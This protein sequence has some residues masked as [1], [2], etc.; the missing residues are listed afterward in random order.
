[1]KYMALVL[2][3][4]VFCGTLCWMLHTQAPAFGWILFGLGSIVI[5]SIFQNVIRKDEHDGEEA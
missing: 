4:L 3:Y 1:M 5:L 2:A